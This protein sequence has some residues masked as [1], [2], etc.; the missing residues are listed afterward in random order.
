MDSIGWLQEAVQMI[1]TGPVKIPANRVV[2]A[3]TMK[4]VVAEFKVQSDED[5][6]S[7]EATLRLGCGQRARR[8]GKPA[9]KPTGRHARGRLR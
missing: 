9:G 3:A 1:T 6:T 8:P 7:A 2:A 5:G 4:N